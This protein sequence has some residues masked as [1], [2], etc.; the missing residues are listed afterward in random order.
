MILYT[1]VRCISTGKQG[2]ISAKCL[3]LYH[4]VFNDNSKAWLTLDKLKL[5]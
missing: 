3:H 1:N 5:I 4:V 2:Y